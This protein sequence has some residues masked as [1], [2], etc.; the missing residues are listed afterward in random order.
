MR[1]HFH[2]ISSSLYLPLLPLLRL[3][4]LSR[5]LTPGL[6]TRIRWSR[7]VQRFQVAVANLA[8]GGCG[9]SVHPATALFTMGRISPCPVLR[10]NC[11]SGCQLAMCVGRANVMYRRTCRILFLWR[12]LE[13]ETHSNHSLAQNF[14]AHKVASLRTS[15]SLWFCA[16]FHRCAHLLSCVKMWS[17]FNGELATYQ[18]GTGKMLPVSCVRVARLMASGMPR[19]TSSGACKGATSAF[20]PQSTGYRIRTSNRRRHYWI[21]WIK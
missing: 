15:V 6:A 9:G 1:S 18:H 8:N 21:R 12:R 20:L 14:I 5:C 7:G 2:T 16:E 4:P 13:G 3:Q 17:Y 11:W 19:S 10:A